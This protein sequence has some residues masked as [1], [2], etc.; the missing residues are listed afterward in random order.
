MRSDDE[1]KAD[2]EKV[3]NTLKLRE[4]ITTKPLRWFNGKGVDSEHIVI[5]DF[6]TPAGYEGYS[7]LIAYKTYPKQPGPV[8]VVFSNLWPSPLTI[9][10][11]DGTFDNVKGFIIEAIT[12]H[13]LTIDR[14]RAKS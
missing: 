13:C 11:W 4:G 5:F 9:V 14:E 3:F 12:G 1:L 10:P 8:L 6:T 7:Q 2:F